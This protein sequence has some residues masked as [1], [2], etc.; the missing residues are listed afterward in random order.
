MEFE[1]L[2][3]RKSFLN[4][5]CPKCDVQLPLENFQRLANDNTR[6]YLQEVLQ[7]IPDHPVHNPSLKEFNYG[8]DDAGFMKNLNGGHKFHFITQ[9]H[10]DAVGDA[11]L[12]DVQ[13][14]MREKYE[15]EELQLPPGADP[16]TANNIFLSRNATKTTEKL[17][18]IIQGSGAVRPGQWARA[19]CLNESLEMGSIFPYLEKAKEAGY[20]VI[21]FNPNQNVY[22]EEVSPP[23][24]RDDFL[25]TERGPARRI[26]TL[27]IKGHEDPFKHTLYV[28]DHFVAKAKARHIV[29]V[30]HSAGGPCTMHLL[31]NRENEVLPRLRAIAFTDSV[32]SPSARDSKNVRNF[33]EKNAINFVTSDKPLDA[34]VSM[35]DCR[36]VSAGHTKHEWTS[37][38]AISSVFKLFHEKVPNDK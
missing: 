23:L 3:K 31:G 13:R 15:L 14:I 22:P 18:L 24:T 38:C 12:I 5:T 10:Y 27:P 36:C 4:I 34:P 19:L 6:Q 9:A 37:G 26:H 8:Y 32:H 33:L 21:V 25:R 16:R 1:F 11:A 29:I 35:R 7:T 30:A 28:W 2:N 17:M 20:E